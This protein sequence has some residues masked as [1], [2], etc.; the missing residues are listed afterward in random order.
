VA[1][2]RAPGGIVSAMAKLVY[3]MITSL[4]GYVNDTDGNI[5]WGRP[6]PEMFEYIN[7]LE[8]GFGTYLYGRRIYETMIF[9]E[10]FDEPDDLLITDFARI[11][12]AADKVVY[13]TSLEGTSSANTR[14]ERTFDAEAVR[15]MKDTSERD[16]T[17][18]GPELAGH[19]FAAGLIDEA[20]M[21]VTPVTVGGGSPAYP[22]GLRVNFELL[23][24]HVFEIGVV[25]LHYQVPHAT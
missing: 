21:F 15:R 10:T 8:R 3:S 4:D 18:A 19:A 1:L 23:G 2:Q 13:S 9:W 11:W 25:H 14:I 17:I 7:E 5:E 22:R 6:D 12:R 24:S 16:I 20:H